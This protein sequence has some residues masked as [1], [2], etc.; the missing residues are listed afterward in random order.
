[1]I[2]QVQQSRVSQNTVLYWMPVDVKVSTNNLDTVFV[3]WDSLESQSF[4][5][6]LSEE[7]VTIEFDPDNWILKRSEPTGIVQQTEYPLRE[8]AL[9]QN[10]PIP[11]NPSTKISFTLPKPEHVILNIYNTLGLK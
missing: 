10:Y 4:E 7:P 9:F 11:F 2:D 6:F 5:F 1:M 3:V 8:F